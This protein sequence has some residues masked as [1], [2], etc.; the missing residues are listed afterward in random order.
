MIKKYF[1]ALPF[2]LLSF[3][4]A[5]TQPYTAR[6]L[7]DKMMHSIEN[8]HTCSYNL[9]LK[10]RTRNE[11]R[12]CEYVV[13]VNTKPFKAFAYSIN[14]HPGATA[15]LVHG[16]NDN[17]VLI[18]PNSFPY[19][20]ISLSPQSKMMRRNHLFT[21][22]QLGFEYIGNI[23]KGYF[24]KDSASF[25]KWLRIENEIT[26]RDKKYYTLVIENNL[27]TYNNYTVLKGETISTIAKKLLLNDN[28]I[29]QLNKHVSSLDDVKPGQVIKVPSTFGKK[30]VLYI[31]KSTML[32]AIQEIYDDK[33]L[34]SRIEM[35]SVIKNQKFAADEFT[36]TKKEYGF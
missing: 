30:I 14:P 19:I 27:F 16:E 29:L 5:H 31:D 24:L 34:M 21:M 7:F 1:F 33:G 36:R 12:S 4:Y 18:N 35:T 8:T 3:F 25:L 32:P 13:R 11:Y 6:Q 26:F 28:A 17:K 23:M 20:N 2:F 9:L 22:N 15:L 10:E